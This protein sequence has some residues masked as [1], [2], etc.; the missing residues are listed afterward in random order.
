MTTRELRLVITDVSD[1]PNFTP[2]RAGGGISEIDVIGGDVPEPASLGLLLAGGVT[3]LRR[4][5][6]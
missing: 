1:A 3:L 5:R 6:A 4:R 2:D